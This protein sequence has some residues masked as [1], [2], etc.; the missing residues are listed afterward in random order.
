MQS[1]RIDLEMAPPL[2]ELVCGDTLEVG[3][4]DVQLMLGDAQRQDV[5]DVLVGHG[6]PVAAV[7]DEAVDGAGAVDDPRGVIR[8]ARQR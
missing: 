3:R 8:V 7:V 2:G 1:R 5:G 6:I 4:V